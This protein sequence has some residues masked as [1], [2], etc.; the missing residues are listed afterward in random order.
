M[1]D[2]FYPIYIQLPPEK[3]VLVKFLLESYEGIGELR[4]IDNDKAEVVILSLR[5]TKDHVIKMLESEKG[6]LDY[7]IIE[8]PASLSRDWLLGEMEQTLESLSS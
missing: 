1:E 6:S 3:I 7:K 4:T 2:L 5:D 8:K